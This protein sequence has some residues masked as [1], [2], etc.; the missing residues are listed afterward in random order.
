MKV[1]IGHFVLCFAISTTAAKDKT[2][3]AAPPASMD[4][5]QPS[6]STASPSFSSAHFLRVY[7]P[8]SAFF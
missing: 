4:L 6:N 8:L 1:F 5:V 3:P 7:S 2:V